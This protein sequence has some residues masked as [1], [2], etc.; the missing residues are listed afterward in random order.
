[1]STEDEDLASLD[2]SSSDSTDDV[3]TELNANIDDALGEVQDI[4]ER[5]VRSKVWYTVSLF[6]LGS[7]LFSKTQLLT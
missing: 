1:M 5:V 7:K 6:F 2:I 3:E 4:Q